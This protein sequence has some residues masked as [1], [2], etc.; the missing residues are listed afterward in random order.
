MKTV[1][2]GRMTG[3]ARALRER[4][5]V[6]RALRA[7]AAR[8]FTHPPEPR[9]TGTPERGRD[10]LGG[11]LALADGVL[12]APGRA[13]WRLEAP[14]PA[15]AEALHGFLWLDDLAALGDAPARA[16]AREWTEAWIARH[17]RGRPPGWSAGVL[18]TRLMRWIDHGPFLL[19]GA[20]PRFRR[21]FL[22]LLGR[23]VVVL[24]R[25][26]SLAPPGQARIAALATLIR[27][28]TALEGVAGN[29]DTALAALG[30]ES[31]L[32]I[33]EGGG[34]AS[35]NP[36]ELLNILT[37]LTGTSQDLSEAG[38]QTPKEVVAA[39]MRAAPTL[40]ALRHADGTLARFHGGGRG[41]PGAV[42]RALADSGVRGAPRG[43]LAMGYARLVSG[44]VSVIADAAPPPAGRASA[45]AHASTL[46]FELTSGRR[47][48]I[49]S[50][51]AGDSFGA[52]WRRAGRATQSHSTLAIEG[53]SSARIGERRR[54]GG[55][56]IEPLVAA[57]HEVEANPRRAG[58]GP[59]LS[60][61]H[62]GY[63][64][65]HG[66][67]HGR[68]LMLA[69]RGRRLM[70]EDTLASPSQAARRA[71]EAALARGSGEGVG[72]AIHFHLHPD[73]EA[74]IDVAR[75]TVSLAVRSGE[76]W[77]FRFSGPAQLSLEA[78]VYLAR[79][80]PRP[81]PTRQIVLASWL[82][83]PPVRIGWTLAKA[84]DTP[85]GIRDLGAETLGEPA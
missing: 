68:T 57:P 13:P 73:V 22:R 14:T 46:A 71:F 19:S 60:A 12:E 50:A 83:H 1:G 69:E 56:L 36:E 15:F 26:W 23:Q 42:D 31:R 74:E 10:I 52:E 67:I 54:V 49:V 25:R 45:G 76:I 70:G 81:C 63:A 11:R 41:A 24:A 51:G 65:S 47:P 64:V 29:P 84:G 27:T 77:L 4:L 7:P 20:G 61:W 72:F 66:L 33:D 2:T 8:G 44:R 34:V 55:R 80:R 3:R 53:H 16:Q 35:R 39:I 40:R 17:G 18:A 37:D 82:H 32:R 59:M 78:S 43:G 79:D 6:W 38:R 5:A 21:R 58:G 62:D 85:Q 28:L 48:V 9:C 75:S 30:R